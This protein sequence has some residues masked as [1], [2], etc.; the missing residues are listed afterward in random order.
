[1]TS[2]MNT[3][4]RLPVAFVRG[5][6]ALLYDEAGT[7][8]LDALSGIAVCSLGHAHP[9]LAQALCDQANTLL[10]TSNLYEIPL[11][12]QLG[13]LLCQRAGM[14]KVFFCNSGAEA[15]ETAIKL[16]RR[17]GHTRG[18]HQ[19]KII[20]MDN[21]FHGRTLSTLSATGN[22][23]VQAGF[24]PLV[25][26]FV[27]VP[28]D[29]LDAVAALSNDPNIVAILVEPIQG[30]G[31]VHIP[32]DDYLPGLRHLCDTNQWLL[33]LDE[34]QTGMGR[35]GQLFAFQHAKIQPDVMTLAKA[36]GNG[37]PIG[38]CLAAGQA[39]EVLVPGSHGTTFGGNPLACRAALEV[40]HILLQENWPQK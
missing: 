5:E 9:R 15:N 11:Q 4:A 33:M 37:V 39:A 34:V 8:Y 25:E 32:A 3:Y 40:V 38:A 27:R 36:L 1:M 17:W 2:L 10:H 20:V 19:P 29:D 14:D 30:E 7:A 23:K 6:G 18:I 12:Q 35:T 31:G 22:A 28:F 24:T 21:S 16:A 13:E 26:G